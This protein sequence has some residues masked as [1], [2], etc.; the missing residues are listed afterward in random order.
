[1]IVRTLDTS[2]VTGNLVEQIRQFPAVDDLGTSVEAGEPVNEDPRRCPWVGVYQ[3]GNNFTVRTLGMTSG[4]R[5]QRIELAI[6]VTESSSSSGRDAETKMEKLIAAVVGAVLSD[7]SI[8][9]SVDT[10]MEEFRVTYSDYRKS[11]NLFFREAVIQFAAE[12]N[13]TVT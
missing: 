3:T 2:I 6:I 4:F 1:M 8:R 13:V 11:G 9:G 5:R 12:L 10:I 7:T